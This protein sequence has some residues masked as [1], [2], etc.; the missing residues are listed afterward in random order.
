MPGPDERLPDATPRPRIVLS[1]DDLEA[2]PEPAPGVT[3]EAG[4]RPPRQ[5][6]RPEP[7]APWPPEPAPP[8]PS[9]PAPIGSSPALPPL[10]GD[11]AVRVL[12][13][14]AVLAI[15]AMLMPWYRAD[16]FGRIT[17]SGWETLVIGGRVILVAA[18]LLLLACAADVLGGIGGQDPVDRRDLGHVVAVLGALAA[19]YVLVRLMVKPEFFE[20]RSTQFGIDTGADSAAADQ[21]Q[22]TTLFGAILEF[23]TLSVA[24]ATGYALA[25]QAPGGFDLGH[26]RNLLTERVRNR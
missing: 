19:A 17:G 3:V 16:G 14:A 26:A 10:T 8:A 11:L 6:T 23:L 4:P 1:F 20:I 7:P 12:G 9:Q 18:V 2:P 24:A 25:R 15:I 21:V 13:G 5:A 22:I